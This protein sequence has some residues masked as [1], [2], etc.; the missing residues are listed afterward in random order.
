[1]KWIH[2]LS[3]KSKIQFNFYSEIDFW[4]I[5]CKWIRSTGIYLTTNISRVANHLEYN[6][7]IFSGLPT[8]WN[9]KIPTLENTKNAVIT[10]YIRIYLVP[11]NHLNFHLFFL[12]SP[13]NYPEGLINH[14]KIIQHQ[15]WLTS[16]F[17]FACHV[18]KS[19]IC[20]KLITDHKLENNRV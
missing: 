14:Q 1:M 17:F 2:I 13:R 19:Y 9:I 18:I 7:L 11:V 3:W 8:T 16:T 10:S 12:K 4:L 15:G 5:E 20:E 6:D